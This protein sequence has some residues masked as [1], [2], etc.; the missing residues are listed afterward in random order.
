M[1]KPANSTS[2]SPRFYDLLVDSI[3]LMNK[4]ERHTAP[5]LVL[6]T[7]ANAIIQTV[8]MVMI[9]P[10]VR[11]ILEPEALTTMK[12]VRVVAD[13]LGLATPKEVFA[14]FCA[15]VVG[16]VLLKSTVSWYHVDV[17]G[18]FAAGCE[19]RLAADLFRR[20]LEAPYAWTLSTNSVVLRDIVLHNTVQ[21]SR[22][23]IRGSLQLASDVVFALLAVGTLIVASPI[24]GLAAA[25]VAG[26][27]AAMFLRASQPVQARL[28][29]LK[30]Q[31]SRSST[32][33]CAEALSGAKDVRMAAAGP[34]FLALFT[35][36][37]E[38]YAQADW[39][40]LLWRNAPRIGFE[41]IAYL[42]MIAV[43]L[44]AIFSDQSRGDV[45]ALLALYVL[46]AIR[47]LP[48]AASIV[49]SITGVMDVAPLVDEMKVMLDQT[50]SVHA[51]LIDQERFR[52]WQK[53]EIDRVSYTYPSKDRPSLA[54]LSASIV[55]G[56]AYGI[57]GTSGSGKTTLVDILSG[58]LAP[59]IGEVRVD[60]ELLSDNN[61][62]DWPGR[63]GY[64]SQS[65]FLLAASLADNITL[66]TAGKDVD[67]SR[68]EAVVSAAMLDELVADLPDGLATDLGERGILLSGGQRQRV[69]IAR[70]LYR[71]VDILVLDEATSALDSLSEQEVV[72]SISR[73]RG[74]VTLIVIAHRLSTILSSDEIWHIEQGELIAHGTHEELLR[75]SPTYQQM[76]LVQGLDQ[77]PAGS[78]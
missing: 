6:V 50:R 38:Q 51:D 29:Q 75:A 77:A 18:R 7:L 3:R 35:R 19:R 12:S 55:R 44:I 17:M 46:A 23:V 14:L 61:R 59:T 48:I 1:T 47:L 10:L 9:L 16:V 2:V 65:P 26:G 45:A 37:F 49:S 63:V 62:K 74:K 22:R 70:A 40:S 57:V 36:H 43:A 73:L 54:E 58:L 78:K 20:F 71:D 31:A 28:T 56:R 41:V 64:V 76:A 5:L 60:G 33:V 30:Q 11:F 24:G 4:A 66:G 27:L 68:L 42:T 39:R 52:N 32:L 69:A 21:W 53:I 25:I 67:L 34:Q 15:G 72:R 8:A 13:F